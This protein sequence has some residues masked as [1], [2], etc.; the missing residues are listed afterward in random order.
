MKFA[1]IITCLLACHLANAQFSKGDKFFAGGYSISLQD[2]SNGNGDN[3]KH[4][5]F[6]VSPEIGFFLNE[7]FAV[8]GG[9]TFAS[10]KSRYEYFQGNYQEAKDRGIGVYVFV[11]R[12]FPIS[13]KFFFS[14]DGSINYDRRKNTSTINGLKGSGKSYSIGLHASP[15][16]LFFPSPNWAI[17]GSIGGVGLT[18]SRGISDETKS[19]SFG[20]NYGSISFGFAYYIRRAAE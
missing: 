11:K 12:Y 18:H 6:Q 15:S 5:S 20:I 13:E 2:G 1:A 14:L 4:R 17:E 3:N 8:G 10:S 7:N 19:T 9:L 16:L